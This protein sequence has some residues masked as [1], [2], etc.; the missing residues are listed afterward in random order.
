MPISE[1]PKRGKRLKPFRRLNLRKR[2][3]RNVKQ[4]QSRP[5]LRGIATIIALRQTSWQ[6]GLKSGKGRG[7]CLL[8]KGDNHISTL[9]LKRNWKEKR[10]LFSLQC[11]K[12][13]R[14]VANTRDAGYIRSETQHIGLPICCS[15]TPDKIVRATLQRGERPW[16]CNWPGC[17]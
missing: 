2:C 3:K 6:Q 10:E 5:S 16:S 9:S 15:H 12:K 8:L 4:C 14:F 13:S 7:S 11:L 17:P 1:F